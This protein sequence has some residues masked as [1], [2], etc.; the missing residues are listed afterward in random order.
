MCVCEVLLTL[1]ILGA[2]D[3]V[4]PQSAGYVAPARR[5]R[6]ALHGG[7]VGGA[8]ARAPCAHRVLGRDAHLAG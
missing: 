5:P 1:D 6:L 4:L 2:P 7:A 3:A 8:V